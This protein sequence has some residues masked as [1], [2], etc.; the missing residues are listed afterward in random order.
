[1]FPLRKPNTSE[2]TLKLKH[3]KEEPNMKKDLVE[4]VFIL[5]RSGSMR[6]LESDTIGG[7]NNLLE[8]QRKEKG[9]AVISTV[10]FDHDFDVV[11][12]RNDIQRVEPLTDKQYFVRGSTAM[13]D[14]IGRSILKIREVHRHLGP[15]NVPE[16]T[17]FVIT[18]DGMEN[19]SRDF[20]WQTVKRLISE[21]TENDGWEF[22]FLG[23]NI[24][25]AETAGRMGIRKERAAN[26]VHDE[27]GTET[28]FNVLD[29]EIAY[30]RST[31]NLRESW[32]DD[33]DLDFKT[34]VS[35]KKK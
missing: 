7:F 12:N 20:D 32:K 26:Y 35:K 9:D 5:D 34:R 10:L 30:L 25:A 27:H 14:A 16:K 8:K 23:A 13:L 3:P 1:M 21:S 28:N 29:R 11:H 6:G 2:E 4:L 24:D 15:D 19:A 17:M 22:V 33:I 18:T 31:K